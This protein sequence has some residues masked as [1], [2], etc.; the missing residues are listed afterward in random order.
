MKRPPFH[1][2]PPLFCRG[3]PPQA[4][5]K[6]GEQHSQDCHRQKATGMGLS[7]AQRG[8]DLPGGG[9]DASLGVSPFFYMA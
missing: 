5:E 7:D 3:S 1:S 9:K 2:H 8:Q 6:E 4:G